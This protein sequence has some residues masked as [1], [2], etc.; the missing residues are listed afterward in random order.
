MTEIGKYNN[1]QIVKE[2]DFGLYLDGGKLGEILLPQRYVP[3]NCKVD[4]FLE[5][6][7][8]LDSEDRIIATTEM[9]YATVGDFDLLNVAAVNKFGAFLDWGLLKDLL[10]PFREQTMTMEK[11][12]AYIVH[13]FLDTKTNR[14]VASSKIDKFLETEEVDLQEEQEV[15]L[16]V[17]NKTD[18]GFKAFIRKKDC[19]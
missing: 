11:D 17:C 3:P 9:P 19:V 14:I 15:D 8:Y 10:V 16:F 6:F 4:D 2:V 1:L 18:I 5:V 12:K 7:I 13:V